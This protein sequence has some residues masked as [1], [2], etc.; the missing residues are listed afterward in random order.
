MVDSGAIP[1][2]Y[3]RPASKRRGAKDLTTLNLVVLLIVTGVVITAYISNIIMVDSLMGTIAGLQ[4]N[5]AALSQERE[6]LRA[7]IN[8]LSSY[9]RIQKEAERLDLVHARQQPY[10]LLVPGLPVHAMDDATK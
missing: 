2:A 8:M 4:K 10:S 5:E 6:N 1:A 3:L 7:E 9:T